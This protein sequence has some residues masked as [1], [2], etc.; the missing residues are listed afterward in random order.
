MTNEQRFTSLYELAIEKEDLRTAFDCAVQL[1]YMV[2]SD[3]CEVET[4]NPVVRAVEK[5]DRF[6][7]GE[8]SENLDPREAQPYGPKL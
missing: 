2:N 8:P 3:P 4:G 5:S 7:E 6:K 1:S